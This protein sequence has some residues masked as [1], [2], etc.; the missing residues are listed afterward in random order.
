[1]IEIA[2]LGA[3][4]RMGQMVRAAIAEHPDRLSL[5][6]SV[7]NSGHPGVGAE[8]TG[9]V[10][11][12]DR[13]EN[14]FQSAEVYIDFTSSEG[15][16]AALQVAVRHG[17]AAVIG[18]TGLSADTRGVM[19]QAAKKIPMVY[20]PNFSLGVN[21]L[22]RLVERAAAVLPVEYD[23]E[24]LEVH[25]RDKK[26]AP[27]G[28][29]LALGESA[30][31]GR[32]ETLSDVQ[33]TDRTGTSKKS[34]RPGEIGFQALR[35]GDVVGEHTVCFFGPSERIELTHRASSRSIFAQGAVRAATWVVGQKPGIYDMADV[36]GLR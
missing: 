3:A 7:E 21:V 30:A 16:A 19:D 27:S 24:I 32:D 23:I 28:T 1:M 2:V 5:V 36:L 12:I 13:I 6:A 20:A 9:G 10:R 31:R 34:R 25:H 17:V 18:T 22:M 8:V 29:A 15:T 35:G 4:G 11:T 14:A 26:D 33:R